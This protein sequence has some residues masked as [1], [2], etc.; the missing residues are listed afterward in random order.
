MNRNITSARSFAFLS[1]LILISGLL[2]SECKA[3]EG[4][5]TGPA[6]TNVFVLQTSPDNDIKFQLGGIFE[7]DYRFY[8]EEERADNRFFV[9]RAQMEL[10]AWIRP[11]LK[12]NMEYELKNNVT[13][14]LMDT[15]AQISF[16]SH[17][18]KI[19][20]FK[21]PFSLE[22]ANGVESVYFAERSMGKSLSPAR[23]VGAMLSGSLDNDR[24]NYSFGLFNAEGE[25]VGNRG[26]G[27]DEPEAA[28][29]IVYAPFAC[30][31]N[32]YLKNFQFGVSGTYA[33]IN[34]SNLSIKVKTTGMIDTNR[35]IYVLGHDTKFGVLQEADDRRRIGAEAAWAWKS[36]ACQA[37]YFSLSYTSLKPVGGSAR[38]ADLY[39]YYAGM[40]Y[41]PTGEK[42][43][44]NQGIMVRI[45]PE[46]PFNLSTGDYGALGIALRYDHFQ[47]DKD[48]IN[49]ASYVSVQ[50]ADSFSIALNWIP[51][52]MNRI[53]LDYTYTDLSDPIR[54]RVEADGTVKYIEKENVITL[55]YSIDF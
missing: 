29:R 26:D 52:S 12:L 35:N 18:V 2:H 39:S 27:N 7:T 10:S 16:G 1:L 4:Y 38:N 45:N 34:L 5:D 41:F 22:M 47:G 28:V 15:Y 42:P 53:L 51:A 14:H 21:K 6:A 44:F 43:A 33:E 24:L 19:G 3:S 30:S 50:E 25:E 32:E 8:A 17:Y 31:E 46:K 20:H 13:D 9:R 48:W 23:D 49:P 55:A 37:E 40:L 36:F 54:V 11:W